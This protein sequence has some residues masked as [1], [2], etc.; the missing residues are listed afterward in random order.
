[1]FDYSS[2]TLKFRSNLIP[3][4]AGLLIAAAWAIITYRVLRLPAPYLSWVHFYLLVAVAGGVLV[5]RVYAFT[6]AVLSTLIILYRVIRTTDPAIR[7][8]VL[9]DLALIAEVL[10]IFFAVWA[11]SELFERAG[12]LHRSSSLKLQEFSEE[13]NLLRS[14]REKS[15]SRLDG[16][17]EKRDRFRLLGGLTSALSETLKEAAV[18]QLVLERAAVIIPGGSPRFFLVDEGRVIRDVTPHSGTQP[19]HADDE[20]N[21]TILRTASV[22]SVE[23]VTRDFRFRHSESMAAPPIADIRVGGGQVGARVLGG[24]TMSRLAEG[25]AFNPGA[26]VS[27]IAAPLVS[28]GVV[29]GLLR[30]NSATA[31]AFTTDDLRLLSIIAQMASIALEN[32][33]LYEKTE[34]MAMVD[35]LTRLYKRWYFQNRFQ[36]ECHRFRRYRSGASVLMIDIDHFK[37]FNDTHGHTFGDRVLRRVAEIVK[38]EIRPSDL[39]GRYGGEEFSVLMPRC[40]AVEAREIGEKVRRAVESRAAEGMPDGVK[41]TVSIGAAAC[42]DEIGDMQKAIEEADRALYAAKHGG[43]N[44]VVSVGALPASVTS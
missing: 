23:D 15:E 14:E 26:A 24:D 10:L 13:A 43:R 35:G 9:T 21:M 19:P 12:D 8:D 28:R 25:T 1:V 31:S 29:T 2:E 11:T 18:I 6:F 33:R 30:M 27:L 44:R 37:S 20:F 41:V 42:P 16:L 22:L 7:T 40:G 5:G 36:E 17:R 38:A 4:A 3:V 39:A 34:E 32:A